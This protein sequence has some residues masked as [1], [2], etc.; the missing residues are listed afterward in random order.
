MLV[1]I[2]TRKLFNTLL[3]QLTHGR[4]LN[5]RWWISSPRDTKWIC[6]LWKRRNQ[7]NF[8]PRHASNSRTP[9]KRRYF[10]LLP[11]YF[12]KWTFQRAKDTISAR[13]I[14]SNLT[15]VIKKE[16]GKKR[17]GEKNIRKIRHFWLHK[18]LEKEKRFRFI[19]YGKRNFYRLL[20]TIFIDLTTHRILPSSSRFPK[21]MWIR[22]S[23]RFVFAIFFISEII[24]N[25]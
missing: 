12:S 7:R 5:A 1:R 4:G 20:T 22:F 21:S 15:A 13:V 9:L 16:E 6:Y 24:K 23:N 17:K 18:D 19:I 3:I 11:L 14:E 10:S 25:T 2:K 8:P